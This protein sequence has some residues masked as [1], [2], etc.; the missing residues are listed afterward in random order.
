MSYS[1]NL[2]ILTHTN[3]LKKAAIIVVDALAVV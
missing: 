3:S 2:R 1:L